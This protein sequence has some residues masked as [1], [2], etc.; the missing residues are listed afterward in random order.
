MGRD[1]LTLQQRED[2]NRVGSCV[3][4]SPWWSR[5]WQPSLCCTC[6]PCWQLGSWQAALRLQVCLC[7]V[8]TEVTSFQIV[9][10]SCAQLRREGA[11]KGL[12]LRGLDWRWVPVE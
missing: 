12:G 8:N 2:V 1:Q 11:H 5:P 3:Q 6:L 4:R 10:C 7:Q 9:R